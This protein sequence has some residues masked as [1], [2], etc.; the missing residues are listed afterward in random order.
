MSERSQR[1]L[2]VKALNARGQNAIPVENPAFPGTPDV[3]YIGGW[4]ELKWI[5]E[6]PKR[7][8]TVVRI[9]HYTPQQ[10]VFAIR[11]RLAGGTCWLLLQC[12]REWLLFDSAVAATHING[13]TRTELTEV[14]EHVSFEG[15]K[16]GLVDCILQT[17]KD[18]SL[19]DEDVKRLN[20]LLRKGME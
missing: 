15:L 16:E 18:Y 10:R 12:R 20:R 17:Q 19:T 11:R 2:V 1:T 13:S 9:D 14:A 6:W 5:E 4:I 3:N 7:N 8:D